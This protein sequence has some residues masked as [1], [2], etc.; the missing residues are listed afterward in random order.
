MLWLLRGQGPEE[1]LRVRGRVMGTGIHS[2]VPQGS[3]WSPSLRGPVAGAGARG[4]GVGL[5]WGQ[6]VTWEYLPMGSNHT[7]FPDIQM[8][9]LSSPAARPISPG[10]LPS[11]EAV[12]HFEGKKRREG[13]SVSYSPHFLHLVGVPW[14]SGY[15]SVYCPFSSIFSAGSGG[16]LWD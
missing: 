10:F 8:L 12:N 13:R 2:H 11:T 15:S 16:S 6:G 14:S 7:P 1:P 9:P 5:A 4:A 3:P